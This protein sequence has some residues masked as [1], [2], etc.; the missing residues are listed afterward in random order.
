MQTEIN[1]HLKDI[2]ETNQKY[3]KQLELNGELRKQVDETVEQ[4]TAAK[5][6]TTQLKVEL[7]EK[8]TELKESR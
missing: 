6:E 3:S 8:V 7:Q 5:L 2:S 1:D 4:L